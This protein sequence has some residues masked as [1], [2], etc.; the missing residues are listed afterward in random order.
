MAFGHLDGPGDITGLT[1]LIPTQE[2]PVQPCPA[3]RVVDLVSG[4][5]MHPHLMDALADDGFGIAKTR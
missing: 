5:G 2:K 4:P 3:A 1:R